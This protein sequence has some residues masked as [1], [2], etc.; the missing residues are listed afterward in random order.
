MAE[1]KE[2]LMAEEGQGKPAEKAEFA[3]VSMH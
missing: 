2:A 1:T 3:R